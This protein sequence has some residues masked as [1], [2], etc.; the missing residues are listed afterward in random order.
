M[1]DKSIQQYSEIK[2]LQSNLYLNGSDN[3]LFKKILKKK[4]QHIQDMILMFL[5]LI[6]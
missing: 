4:F 1:F 2:P 6:G 3:C 5:Y